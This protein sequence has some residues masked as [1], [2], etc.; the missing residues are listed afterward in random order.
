[1]AKPEEDQ[2]LL[3]ALDAG[4]GKQ[5][6]KQGRRSDAYDE[7]KHSYTSPFIYSDGKT[8]LLISHGADY[9]I[10]YNPADGAEVWRKGGL[11]P[12]DN[13]NKKYHRTL[14]F[15][16]SPTAVPGLIVI[17]T[18][19]NGPVVAIRP[20]GKGD[21]S[22]AKSQHVW[23]RPNNT[24]DVPC[25]LIHDGLVY[26][27]RENGNLIC[28]DARTGHEYYH[29]RTH[30]QRHRASPVF[31]DG[32]VICVARDGMISVVQA[33]K[34]FKMLA[35]NNLGDSITAGA[36]I[37]DR[38]HSAYPGWLNDYLGQPF[39]VR[40]FGAGGATM[41]RHADRPYHKTQAFR[42]AIAWQPHIAFV[43][44]GT[45][46]TCE[47]ERRHNWRHADDLAMDA[48]KLVAALHAA[49][50][51]MRVVL[52]SPTPMFADKLGLHPERK[53]DL[54]TRAKRLASCALAMQ[55][56]AHETE[57]V[58]YLE[59]RSTLR[60]QDVSDGVHPT[61]FGAERVARRIAEA[62]A[63]PRTPS[64]E[65]RSR[66]DA[67]LAQLE[68]ASKPD[69]FHGFAGI[70]FQL[71]KT[72]ATCRVF[73]PIGTA[74]GAPWV[75]RARFFGHQPA[76]DIA[77]LERGF[78]LVH[79]DVSNLYGS[80]QAIDRYVELHS[81]LEHTGLNHRAVLEGMSRGGLQIVNWALAYPQRIAAIYGDNPVVDIRSWPGGNSGKR[82]TSDWQR[83]IH[84]PTKT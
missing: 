1:G 72:S 63:S 53:A 67:Q 37:A 83:C 30:R 26:L 50:K 14:R 36:R 39:E 47:N 62:I 76:L 65:Q 19:K 8:R 13:P 7:N 38:E 78:H 77:L 49:R 54:E 79:C 74:R 81:L 9:T 45:N 73:S 70:T 71:P 48:A 32:K 10:A 64:S 43:I 40:N 84:K 16:A 21:I 5:I 2:G 80:Q 60:A 82:S 15:V 55:T 66:L 68:V 34:T 31:V 3:V 29:E 58:E 6:W 44:L 56:V 35:Q 42:D 51:D 57:H 11:N 59:L 12:Q 61:A 69:T 23:T 25:P 75:L 20:D 27:C 52:C 33:G 18:A 22:Y 28:M 24:P 46:D 41:L 4:T 17:P